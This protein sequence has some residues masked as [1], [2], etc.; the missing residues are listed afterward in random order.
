VDADE[1]G[2]IAIMV[3]AALAERPVKVVVEGLDLLVYRDND[4][5]CVIANRCSHAGG[6]LDRGR[7]GHV[8]TVPTVTCPLHGSMFS[9]VDGR[10]LRG[11]A[12]KAQQ[13]FEAREHDGT[14]EIRDP[15]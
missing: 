6:P 3:A 15:S 4:R 14:I 9:L 2:W 8:G 1:G 5:V 12:A 13:A 7:I 11:P 10:V